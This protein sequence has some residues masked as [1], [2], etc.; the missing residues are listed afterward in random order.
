MERNRGVNCAKTGGGL[1]WS[2]CEQGFVSRGEILTTSV[3][4]HLFLTG[5]I[6]IADTLYSIRVSQYV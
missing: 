3:V 1:S 6:F 2:T 5:E 4:S